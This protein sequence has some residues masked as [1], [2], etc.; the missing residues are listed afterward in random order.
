MQAIHTKKRSRLGFET[1]S[2]FG[3][4]YTSHS[5]IHEFM[6]SR[7]IELSSQSPEDPHSTNFLQSY[8]A[9]RN[10]KGC[11]QLSEV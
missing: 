8:F 1:A 5:S 4:I 9:P 6:H 10:R 11:N 2:F 3:R 7:I